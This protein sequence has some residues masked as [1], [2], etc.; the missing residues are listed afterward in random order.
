MGET[1]RDRHV[2]RA[3]GLQAVSE[4]LWPSTSTCSPTRKF[5]QSFLLGFREAS[6]HRHDG[7]TDHRW[8]I[9]TP[10]LLS[11]RLWGGTESSHLPATWAVLPATSPHLQVLSKSHLI[12]WDTFVTLSLRKFPGFQSSVT[13]RGQ[14]PN[15]YFLHKSQYHRE[16]AG[17]NIMNPDFLQEGKY[18]WSLVC[19][20]LKQRDYDKA[21]RVLMLWGVPWGGDRLA[22]SW[23]S[24][25]ASL[26]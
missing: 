23:T 7:F 21:G 18:L 14:R 24:H 25:C 8:L 26:S 16:G 6:S 12:A 9:E 2:G 5:S 11:Q 1:H 3:R 17:W 19:K 13:G 4:H 22:V 20:K 10:A 15:I